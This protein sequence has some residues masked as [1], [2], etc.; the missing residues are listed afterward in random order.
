MEKTVSLPLKLLA[1]SETF[2]RTS[3]PDIT[4]LTVAP[5]GRSTEEQKQLVMERRTKIRSLAQADLTK[6]R[7]RLTGDMLLWD[8]YL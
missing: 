5:H 2:S 1:G 4:P 3:M 6:M 7:K 8:G